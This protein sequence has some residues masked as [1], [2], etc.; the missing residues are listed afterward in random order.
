MLRRPDQYVLFL[1]IPRSS[2]EHRD[3]ADRQIAD[4]AVTQPRHQGR[5]SFPASVAENIGVEQVPHRSSSRG[6]SIRR[7]GQ[8]EHDLSG[9]ARPQPVTDDFGPGGE[10]VKRPP[11][12]A[13]RANGARDR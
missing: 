2:S 9:V 6:G 8:V 5:R 13:G 10:P 3:D 1:R 11:P 12:S 7:S 4:V